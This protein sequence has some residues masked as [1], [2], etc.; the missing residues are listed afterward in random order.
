VTTRAIDR[1]AIRKDEDWE[2]NNAAFTRPL[3]KK[4]FIVSAPPSSG[5]AKLSKSKCGKSVGWVRGGRLSGGDAGIEWSEVN[6]KV[7]MAK[8]H[9]A[10][11]PSWSRDELILALDLYVQFKG[12][13]PGKTAREIM[14]LSN[15]LNQIGTEIAARTAKFRNP[16]GVY[17]KIMNFRR[18]DPHYLAQG[19]KGLQRGGKLEGEIWN[20]FADE[21]DKLSQVS[22]AIR[23]AVTTGSIPLA[24]EEEDE[25][26]AE[27]EEGRIL[28]RLHRARERNRGVVDKKK[29]AAI[30][31]NGLLKCEACSFDFETTYGSRGTGFMEAH[32]IKPVHTLFPGSKTR[33]E[34]LVLLCS[35]CHRMVHARRPWLT[36]D[37]LKVLI[38]F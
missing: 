32:H 21:P 24:S 14:E 19:K 34:D 3:C 12:N 29:V 4:G 31:A 10:T 1:N 6:R 25:E 11:N 35:N 8:T 28:T 16:N 37:E 18:F 20:D 9:Q 5:T 30:K 38:R 15:I 2:G 27:A 36:I 17:M 33:L 23:L 26:F 22:K 7:R 13:P